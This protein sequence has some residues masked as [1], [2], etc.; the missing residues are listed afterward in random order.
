MVKEN[1]NKKKMGKRL[2]ELRISQNINQT[3][4]ADYLDLDQSTIAK[5]ESGD[6]SLNLNLLDKLCSLYG[7]SREYIICRE[8]DYTPLNFAFRS[9]N[10]ND[11]DLEAIAAL[12]K[13][14][15]NIKF[16]NEL[17]ERDE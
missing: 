7:C 17:E 4:L 8:D 16:L 13:I 6:R 14:V 9:K 12:N 5:I 10:V 15:L 11:K 1:I 2:K 3:S